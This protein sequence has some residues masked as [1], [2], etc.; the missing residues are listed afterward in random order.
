M[1]VE[2]FTGFNLYINMAKIPTKNENPKGLYQRY[3]LT[4]ACGKPV[5]PE[6]EYFVLKL[7]GNDH[8]DIIKREHM[9]ASRMA[10]L[11]YANKIRPF[12]PKL[13]DDIYDRY[14]E[15]EFADSIV[16]VVTNSNN[17]Y[18]IP[19]SEMDKLA[20]FIGLRPDL[21]PNPDG[22]SLNRIWWD[23]EA[24]NKNRNEEEFFERPTMDKIPAYSKDAF[25][26][27]V[28]D[29]MMDSLVEWNPLEDFNQL[30]MV[31]SKIEQNRKAVNI[32]E[33]YCNITERDGS[34]GNYGHLLF[35]SDYR[36]DESYFQASADQKLKI[37]IK[38]LYETCLK[39]VND[40][41]DRNPKFQQVD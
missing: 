28:E 38:A 17:Y 3:N 32:A 41:F 25:G 29:A 14:N 18:E 37:K 4:K 40:H 22:R 24:W 26:S 34:S 39:Y 27:W 16:P 8:N 12:I 1:P 36:D 7:T 15:D 6:A 23:D 9:K 10:V 21:N 35:S 33:G 13:A 5:D 19:F 11:V 2:S 30:M 31:V 20:I